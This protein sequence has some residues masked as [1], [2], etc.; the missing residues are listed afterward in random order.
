MQPNQPPTV[1]NALRR[2]AA[3]QF[4]RSRIRKIL[5]AAHQARLDALTQRQ[6]TLMLA[7]Y[8]AVVDTLLQK[9]NALIAKIAEEAKG[10]AKC[11]LSSQELSDIINADDQRIGTEPIAGNCV[12]LFDNMVCMAP[13]WAKVAP[14]IEEAKTE[15]GK[16]LDE[17]EKLAQ[18]LALRVQR[19]QDE[20]DKALV[21]LQNVRQRLTQLPSEPSFG[22]VLGPLILHVDGILDG[23][24]A[25]LAE[26]TGA[27]LQA[28]FEQVVFTFGGAS[29]YTLAT[30]E[31][32][33][34][35]QVCLDQVGECN[36]LLDQLAPARFTKLRTLIKTGGQIQVFGDILKKLGAPG[37][38]AFLT[39][40]ETVQ[41]GVI[42][43]W[44]NLQV[45]LLKK[46][47]P[48]ER[49][50]SILTFYFGRMTVGAN[51]K[52]G[53]S[54][55]LSGATVQIKLPGGISSSGW[56]LVNSFRMPRAFSHASFETDQ[57]CLKHCV[58]ELGSAP[59]EAKITN[60]FAQLC[61][62]S[63]QA[64]QQWNQTGRPRR[65]IKIT[66]STV[67]WTFLLKTDRQSQRPTIFH[68]DSGYQNSPWVLRDK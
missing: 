10:Q 54:A 55:I 42:E 7:P 34:L 19:Q 59:S 9:L 24:H 67:T 23:F 52:D 64:Y 33:P 27:K 63:A 17:A 41:A 30:E 20:H 43:R 15:V 8:D 46:V 26:C 40:S 3:L 61:N 4:E 47:P 6:K 38:F 14:L 66:I 53:W 60:Y 13:T 44:D 22:A 12:Y 36:I 18:G 2:V 48:D 37:Y 39:C 16:L 32:W 50:V 45:E 57:L 25:E 31:S 28:Q 29:D 68:V 51:W 1:E 56:R 62:A 35:Y 65:K 58:Q 21:Q 49:E 5:R 11:A